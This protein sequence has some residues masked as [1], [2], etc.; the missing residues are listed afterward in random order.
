MCL[1]VK[2]QRRQR[3]APLLASEGVDTYVT[4]L[5]RSGSLGGS[6]NEHLSGERKWLDNASIR[7]TTYDAPSSLSMKVEFLRQSEAA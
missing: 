5:R 2:A 7:R 6:Q 1:D 3:S 4:R